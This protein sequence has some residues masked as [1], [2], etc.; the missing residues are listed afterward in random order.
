MVVLGGILKSRNDCTLPL[1]RPNSPFWTFLP[2]AAVSVFQRR[3]E[4]LEMQILQQRLRQQLAGGCR[5]LF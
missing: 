5:T 1:V 4:E 2:S 3:I